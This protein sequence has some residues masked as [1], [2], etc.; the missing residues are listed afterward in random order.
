VYGVGAVLAAAAVVVALFFRDGAFSLLGRTQDLTGRLDIWAEVVSLAERRPWFGWGYS[1]PWLPGAVPFDEP[2]VR[3][4][5]EQLQAH[6]AWLDVWLQLGLVGVALFGGI[7]VSVLWR[8][9]FLAV[10]RPRA[11]RVDDQPYTTV[12]LLPLLV[13]VVLVVQSFMESRI[14]IES[15]WVLLVALAVAT[16][17]RPIVTRPV[18]EAA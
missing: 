7:V 18:D 4:G 16:K 13:A 9:W 2:I 1:S 6:N 3:N 12:A 5:V 8:A 15:G 14:L 17:A 10:D 11:G